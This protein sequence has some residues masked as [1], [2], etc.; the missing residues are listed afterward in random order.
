MLNITVC[1]PG[2]MDLSHFLKHFQNAKFAE[3]HIDIGIGRR[4][5]RFFIFQKFIENS[6]YDLKF[7]LALREN[8]WSVLLVLFN[9]NLYKIFSDNWTA[10]AKIP[11]GWQSITEIL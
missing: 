11:T 4:Y 1:L 3:T 8:I 9:L 6:N 5:I 7:K 2:G 10:R